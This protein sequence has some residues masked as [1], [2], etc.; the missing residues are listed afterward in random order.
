MPRPSDLLRPLGPEKGIVWLR[1]ENRQCT[2]ALHACVGCPPRSAATSDQVTRLVFNLVEA[3]GVCRLMMVSGRQTRESM[4]QVCRTTPS[5][6]FSWIARLE[7]TGLLEAGNQQGGDE[8]RRGMDV[9]NHATVL[10]MPGCISPPV[11]CLVAVP[12]VISYARHW[13][14]WRHCLWIFWWCRVHR[15]AVGAKLSR[16]AAMER[17]RRA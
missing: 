11:F 4:K 3:G 10:R 17:D 1:L 14:G 7:C 15:V 12:S 2:S 6:V 8:M 16:V 5:E 9:K 13:V